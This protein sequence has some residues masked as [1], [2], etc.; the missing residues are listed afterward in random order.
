MLVLHGPKGLAL[1]MGKRD[2]MSRDTFRTHGSPA[3]PAAATTTWTA[4]G[5]LL[6]A[7][8]ALAGCGSSG[9]SSSTASTSST[10][11]ATSASAT[12]STTP[13]STA[14]AAATSSSPAAA[15][16]GASVP[17]PVAVGDTWKYATTAATETGTTINKMTAVVPVASGQQV[18][19]TST[20]TLLGV[21]TN[22]TFTYVFGSDGSITYPLSQFGSSSGVTLSGSGVLWPPAAVIDSGT[23]STSDLKIS[24]NESGVKLST[25]AHITVQGAG[26]ASV[27]V[28]AGTYQATVVNMTIAL[29]VE[30]ISVTEQVKTWLASGVGPVKDEVILDEAGTNHVEASE[31]LESFT[32]G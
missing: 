16:S 1:V 32:K 29:T 13:T 5:C 23:P 22:H 3:R 18:T 31:E 25:T 11:T 7:A 12:T 24:I 26:T 17:F 28:P 9:T 14:S 15:G 10:P 8:L 27:T 20:S 19:V 21:T 2:H 30:G 4:V 6:A